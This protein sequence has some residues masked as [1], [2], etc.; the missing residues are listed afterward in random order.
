MLDPKTPREEY[1]IKF[2]FA[3]LLASVTSATVSAVVLS[4]TDPDPGAILFGGAQLSGTSVFQTVKGGLDGV[5]YGLLCRASDGTKTF[6]LADS[7]EV[8]E[9]MS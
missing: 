6:E 7:I 1:P 2:D 4:G 5:K 3:A 8:R 9:P